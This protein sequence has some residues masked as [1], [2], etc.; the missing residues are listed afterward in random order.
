MWLVAPL[1]FFASI[2][3]PVLKM[4]GPVYLLISAQRGSRKRRRNR[5]VMYRVI[6]AVGR[7]SMIDIS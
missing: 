2:T 3:V 4:A 1:V 5:T 7:W 6:E